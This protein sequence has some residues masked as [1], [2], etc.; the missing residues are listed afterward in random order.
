[1]DAEY[2]SNSSGSDSDGE[3]GV[4]RAPTKRAATFQMNDAFEFDLGGSAPGGGSGPLHAW[5]FTKLRAQQTDSSG[6]TSVGDKINKL[7]DRNAEREKNLAV[8]AARGKAAAAAAKK[9]GGGTY[10][11]LPAT[12]HS[13][14]ATSSEFVLYSSF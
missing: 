10:R 9:K 14:A 12:A 13:F 6:R 2:N 7:L 3:D 1:M 5:S 8:I 11:T 4:K